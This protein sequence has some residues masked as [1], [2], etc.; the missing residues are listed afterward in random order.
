MAIIPQ[1]WHDQNPARRNPTPIAQARGMME[2]AE[3]L[4]DQ[5]ADADVD[6]F[7]EAQSAYY[8]VKDLKTRRYHTWQDGGGLSCWSPLDRY[9]AQP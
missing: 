9:E 5:L 4:L 1:H 2:R 8:L 6:L 3:E 7:R